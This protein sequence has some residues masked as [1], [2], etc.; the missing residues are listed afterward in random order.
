MTE[1]LRSIVSTI[2]GMWKSAIFG[3]TTLFMPS[4]WATIPRKLAQI[5]LPAL[6]ATVVFVLLVGIATIVVVFLLSDRGERYY[7]PRWFRDLTIIILLI[8]VITTVTYYTVKLWVEGEASPFE[9]IDRAWQAGME[10]LERNRFDLRQIPLFL[11][12]GS[13]GPDQNRI[14]FSAARLSL[15]FDNVPPGR[16]S[17][18]WYANQDAIYLVCTEVGCLSRLAQLARQGGVAA[19]A[20]PAP[21]S[22]GSNITGTMAPSHDLMEAA[23]RLSVEREA[24]DGDGGAAAPVRAPALDIR[25]TMEISTV[26]VRE[27]IR[28]HAA[29]RI[30]GKSLELNREEVELQ[31]RRLAYLCKLIERNRRPLCG[32]NGVMTLV[33]NKLISADSSEGARTKEAIRNDLDGLIAGLKLRFPVVALVTGLEEEKGFDELIRRVGRERALA[34]RFGK[35]FGVWDPPIDEEIEALCKHACGAFEDWSY[36]LFKEP[37]SLSKPGNRS[38]YM[39]LCKVRRTLQ[40]RLEQILVGGYSFDA[41]KQSD[42]PPILFAGCYFAGTGDVPERQAFVKGVFER[43]PEQQEELEWTEA[44]LA[45]E[46]RY[47]LWSTIAFSTAGLFLLGIAFVGYQ[48]YRSR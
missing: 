23:Q 22:A 9:D 31:R 19:A 13:E 7:A 38:L 28:P 15:T 32:V 30:L 17:L 48:L 39:L 35:G 8:I 26:D 16:E 18:H 10:A 45:E 41:Q 5:S 29:P 12:L 44:A 34:Q 21:T 3:V 33:S 6:V 25:G 14:L 4:R 11:L 2:V 47:R 20:A 27:T 42:S 24:A 46:D 40:P 43:L 36:Y 37:N 1:F